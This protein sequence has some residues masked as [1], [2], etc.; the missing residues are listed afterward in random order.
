MCNKQKVSYICKTGFSTND[1]NKKYH[2]VK[3]H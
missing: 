2:K 3:D 1:N